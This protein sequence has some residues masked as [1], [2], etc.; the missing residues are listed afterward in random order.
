MNKEETIHFIDVNRVNKSTTLL[1]RFNDAQSKETQSIIPSNDSNI[2]RNLRGENLNGTMTIENSTTVAK[3]KTS[4]RMSTGSEEESTNQEIV[5]YKDSNI[6]KLN[7]FPLGNMVMKDIMTTPVIV[8]ILAAIAADANYFN[9]PYPFML[10]PL[11][12]TFVCIIFASLS[13]FTSYLLQQVSNILKLGTI[14]EIAFYCGNKTTFY[15]VCICLALNFSLD[16]ANYLYQINL[17]VFNV[18]EVEFN[19]VMSYVI[20]IIVFLLFASSIFVQKFQQ[21]KTS[22]LNYIQNYPVFFQNQ[23]FYLIGYQYMGKKQKQQKVIHRIVD[24]YDC[25]GISIG[26]L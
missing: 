5:Y 20:Q 14:E 4:S 7:N 3:Y 2:P 10:N 6:F 9:L 15:F 17:I 16:S 13:C 19:S 18:F 23:T 24:K 8:F 21:L 1:N 22:I 26:T 12:A 25:Q 11:V